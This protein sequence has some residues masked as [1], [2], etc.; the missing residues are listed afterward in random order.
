M[1]ATWQWAK[2]NPD[3]AARQI[4]EL[5]RANAYLH[6]TL[7]AVIAADERA[8]DLWRAA[9]PVN[10]LVIPDRGRLVGWLLEQN[11]ALR[12]HA[13]RV[14]EANDRLVVENDALR[15][16]LG[17]KTK[18][19]KLLSDSLHDIEGVLKKAATSIFLDAC[20]AERKEAQP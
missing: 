15:A 4:R 2:A 14:G 16:E 6:D 9:H 8:V 13:E 3:A 5:E 10:E 20:E 12:A 18:R 11:A 7:D 17:W 19:I 1:S